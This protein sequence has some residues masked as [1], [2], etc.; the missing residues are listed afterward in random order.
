MPCTPENSYVVE[1][2][3]GVV[4][5][6]YTQQLTYGCSTGYELTEGS[7][8]RS[9]QSIGTW[10]NQPPVCTSKFD[11]TFTSP[12]TVGLSITNVIQG[13]IGQVLPWAKEFSEWLGHLYVRNSP[14]I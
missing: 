10:S 3:E 11:L 13:M 5:T 2:V 12:T 6:T 14:S 8:T 1:P 9:C 4:Q 7:L